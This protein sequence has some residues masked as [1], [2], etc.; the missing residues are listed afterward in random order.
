MLKNKLLSVV[1]VLVSTS[2]G[3]T[4]PTIAVSQVQE[5]LTANLRG[6]LTDAQVKAVLDNDSQFMKSAIAGP[7]LTED[8]KQQLLWRWYWLRLSKPNLSAAELKSNIQAAP[9]TPLSPLVVKSQPEEADIFVDD[10]KWPLGTN[11]EGYAEVGSRKI[12]VT[13]KDYAPVEKSCDMYPNKVTT[14]SATL[15]KTGSS[16]S[17]NY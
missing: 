15:G 11:R 2:Y 9:V 14:F 10:V 12:R 7:N 3:L 4:A 1:L 5:A 17:C 6:K 8:A 16:A 13:K